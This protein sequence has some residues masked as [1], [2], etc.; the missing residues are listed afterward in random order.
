M[1]PI[2]GDAPVGTAIEASDDEI[3][4][5]LGRQFRLDLTGKREGRDEVQGQWY[6]LVVIAQQQF[7]HEAEIGD[8]RLS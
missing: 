2:I 4:A 7:F 1:Q 5:E 6:D 3:A 8:E